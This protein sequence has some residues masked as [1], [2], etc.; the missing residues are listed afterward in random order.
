MAS[1][2]RSL[3]LVIAQKNAVGLIPSLVSDYDFAINEQC[4]QYSECGAY[5]AYVQANKAVFNVEYSSRSSYCQGGKSNGLM[6]KYCS[7]SD[8]KC[9]SVPLLQPSPCRLMVLQGSW[10]NCFN[11]SNPLPPTRWNNSTSA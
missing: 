9:T 4:Q 11:P 5:S 6:T 8:G 7:G 10:T 1:Y 3:G 2:A